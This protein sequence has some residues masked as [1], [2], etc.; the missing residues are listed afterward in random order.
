MNTHPYRD[1]QEPV[2]HSRFFFADATFIDL[3]SVIHIE[4]IN[5]PDC[6]DVGNWYVLFDNGKHEIIADEIGASLF[7]AMKEYCLVRNT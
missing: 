2:L 5:N 4:L 3:A 7:R 1:Q 6:E